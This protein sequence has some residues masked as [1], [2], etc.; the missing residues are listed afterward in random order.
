[1]QSWRERDTVQC[2]ERNDKN[3]TTN[4]YK[5]SDATVESFDIIQIKSTNQKY[6]S[7]IKISIYKH[8]NLQKM[9]RSG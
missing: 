8:Q 4:Q 6:K 5:D 1:M 9:R 3:N 2:I 7:K